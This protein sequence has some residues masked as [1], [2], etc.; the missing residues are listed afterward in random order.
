MLGSPFIEEGRARTSDGVDIGS[1]FISLASNMDATTFIV[2]RVMRMFSVPYQHFLNTRISAFIS[3]LATV[4]LGSLVKLLLASTCMARVFA[5]SRT[6]RSKSLMELCAAE[7]PQ[8]YGAAYLNE[9]Y[10]FVPSSSG[11]MR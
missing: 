4:L 3:S 2:V 5:E 1:L 10:F 11:A 7:V 8:R 6:M 9:L